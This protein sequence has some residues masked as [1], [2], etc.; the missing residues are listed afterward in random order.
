MFK[1]LLFASALSL[2]LSV[3]ALSPENHGKLSDYVSQGTLSV[4]GAD[5]IEEV[6]DQT[7]NLDKE[8]LHLTVDQI[9]DAIIIQSRNRGVTL[10]GENKDLLTRNII[11]IIVGLLRPSEGSCPTHDGH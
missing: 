1:L 5:F 6:L 4:Q 2:S 10:E 7:S 11:R 3:H 9:T 8:G